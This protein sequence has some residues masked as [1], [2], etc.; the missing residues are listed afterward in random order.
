MA[1]DTVKT[2]RERIKFLNSEKKLREGIS[3]EE[4]KQLKG[5]RA[6]LKEVRNLEGHQ[7]DILKG[8]LD[9]QRLEKLHHKN[10]QDETTFGK[11]LSAISRAKTKPEHTA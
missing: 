2:I 5:L 3:D 8:A 9:R 10:L 7:K 11:E 1:N 4:R 6:Q